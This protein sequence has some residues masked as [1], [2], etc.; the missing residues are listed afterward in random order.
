M[1]G[2]GH[3]EDNVHGARLADGDP[4]VMPRG[5]SMEEQLE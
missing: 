4:W 2:A 5:A 3:A 1:H